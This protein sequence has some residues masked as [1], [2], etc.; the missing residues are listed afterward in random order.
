MKFRSINLWN[1]RS[2]GVGCPQWAVALAGLDADNGCLASY[3]GLCGHW[4]DDRIVPVDGCCD[5]ATGQAGCDAG[6]GVTV[7]S[8]ARVVGVANVSGKEEML[9]FGRVRGAGSGGG[10]CN[11]DWR[12]RRNKETRRVW[13]GAVGNTWDVGDLDDVGGAS[14]DG[15]CER[16]NRVG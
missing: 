15:R 11:G 7:V 3:D 10:G 1:W 13:V 6:T 14:E 2:I 4:A 8:V 12:N 9:V 16:G 5:A